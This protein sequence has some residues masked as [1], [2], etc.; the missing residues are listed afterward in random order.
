MVEL[1]MTAANAYC[2]V[3]D[4]VD[5]YAERRSSP[6]DRERHADGSDGPGD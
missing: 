3:I 1:Y 4:L 5:V 6:Q 2:R